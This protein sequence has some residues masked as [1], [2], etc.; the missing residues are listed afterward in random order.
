VPCSRRTVLANFTSRSRF[1]LWPV[2]SQFPKS[3]EPAL[4]VASLH[5]WESGTHGPRHDASIGISGP[6][7]DSYLRSVTMSGVTYENTGRNLQ[8]PRFDRSGRLQRNKE[9]TS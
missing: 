9:V 1:V 5:F 6:S 2:H 4:G 7:R 3:G 8:S